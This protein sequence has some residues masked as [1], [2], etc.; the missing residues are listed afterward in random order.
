MA[1]KNWFVRSEAI[2]DK[3]LGAVRYA[4][5]LTDENHPNHR[6][7][8]TINNIH[9]RPVDIA[10]I[11][12]KEAYN[13]DLLN[14]KKQK[15]GRPTSSYLQSFVFS[16]PADVELNN[17]QWKNISKA[18]IKDL[19]DRFNVSTKQLLKYSSLV[20]HKQNNPHLNLIVSRTMDGQSFQQ[21][22]TRPSTTNLLKA[23][24]NRELIKC[25]YDYQDYKPKAR[26]SKRLKRWEE[27]TEKEK[28]IDDKHQSLKTVHSVI[29]KLNN[30]LKKLVLAYRTEDQKN[31]ERQQNRLNRTIEQ[32][33]PEELTALQKNSSLE[34]VRNQLTQLENETGKD[35]ITDKNKSRLRRAP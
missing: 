10:L 11:A 20:L 28:L 13:A 35:I 26:R 18:L 7:K 3:A 23:S 8:T 12:I 5:Y 1:I 33:E 27:L 16:L 30:Q 6:K 15:G 34:Q 32:L 14:A 2:T 24:F 21:A 9:G 4:R 22:L 31:I 19:A 29:R 17:E 25:G